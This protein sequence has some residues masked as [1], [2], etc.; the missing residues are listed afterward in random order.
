M[1][2]VHVLS[3]WSAQQQSLLSVPCRAEHGI[4]DFFNVMALIMSLFQLLSSPFFTATV[5]FL[6]FEVDSN[7]VKK[8]KMERMQTGHVARTGFAWFLFY[9]GFFLPIVL[10]EVKFFKSALEMKTTI[11]CVHRLF[12][13]VPFSLS[14]TNIMECWSNHILDVGPNVGLIHMDPVVA[15]HDTGI[16]HV[17]ELHNE[18]DTGSLQHLRKPNLSLPEGSQRSASCFSA[19]HV[20]C[21]L[22]LLL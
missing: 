22:S 4:T 20:F 8:K 18:G 19:S 3:T 16:L 5:A 9:V 1:C 11:T 7:S 17:S 10:L 13:F 21:I 14:I 15:H 6:K 2:A 12:I